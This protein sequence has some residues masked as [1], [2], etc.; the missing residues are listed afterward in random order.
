MSTVLVKRSLGFNIL[1][2]VC[3]LYSFY[4]TLTILHKFPLFAEITARACHLIRGPDI[5]YLSIIVVTPFV[6]A[7]TSPSCYSSYPHT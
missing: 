6:I 4:Y 7:I 5:S 2:A 3:S 1:D